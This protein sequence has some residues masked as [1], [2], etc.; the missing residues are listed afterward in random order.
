MG[1]KHEQWM[2]RKLL[3]WYLKKK[4][5]MRTGSF[6][7]MRE[8]T[9]STVCQSDKTIANMTHFSKLHSAFKIRF[10]ITYFMSKRRFVTTDHF[11]SIQ[12]QSV[13]KN[14]EGQIFFFYC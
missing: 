1:K 2:M 11:Q 5:E 10:N 3:E 7:L 4:L 9:D 14:F 12:L 8:R 6:N 13:S